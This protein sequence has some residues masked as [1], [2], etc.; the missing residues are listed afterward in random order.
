[1]KTLPSSTSL[2]DLRTSTNPNQ[3]DPDP[4]TG[5]TTNQEL[6]TFPND[7]D[8]LGSPLSGIFRA[9]RELTEEQEEEEG[10]RNTKKEKKGAN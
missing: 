8:F 7:T 4:A 10:K 1:M 6:P 2:D 3:L 5:I 9:K